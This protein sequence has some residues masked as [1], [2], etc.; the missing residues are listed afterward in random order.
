MDDWKNVRGALVVDRD[1]RD[2]GVVDEVDDR[3][4]VV[5]VV[6]SEAQE[7]PV[8]VPLEVVDTVASTADR[9]IL[10]G[11]IADRMDADVVEAGGTLTIPVVAEE[12]VANVREVE[13][14]RAIIEKRV[15]TVP[16]VAKVEVGSDEVDV[17]RVRLDQEVD[18]APT[19]RQE[20]DTLI[21]PVVEEVLVVTKR[22]LVREEVRV[23]KRRVVRQE[24]LREELRREVV[25]VRE[26]R[27][28][29]T[30]R[31]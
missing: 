29:P 18:V 7:Q 22:Y 28:P 6:R 19:I 8:R 13:Q 30:E 10:T 12:A 26:E 9:I 24:T 1:G 20:G 11:A 21:V 2:V 15:E 4:G 23:T 14:G 3:D 25:T 27:T 17:E 16:H 31:S 5:L